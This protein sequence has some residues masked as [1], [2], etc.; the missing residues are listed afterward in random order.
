MDLKAIPQIQDAWVYVSCEVSVSSSRLSWTSWHTSQPSTGYQ[1]ERRS[2][3][4]V[5]QPFL[6]PSRGYLESWLLNRCIRLEGVVTW[7][8]QF[9]VHTV[10]GTTR[11]S[12]QGILF[13]LI[14]TQCI[15]PYSS[16]INIAIFTIGFMSGALMAH[17]QEECL[18][19]L[20]I[21]TMYSTLTTPR[22]DGRPSQYQIHPSLGEGT[23][24]KAREEGEGPDIPTSLA[25]SGLTRTPV[26]TAPG[27]VIG[28][29][30]LIG[31]GLV[32]SLSAW[33]TRSRP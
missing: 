6:V 14:I 24:Q 17:H 18:G 29:W 9:T 1:S 12:Q 19:I 31:P 10:I 5:R 22:I 23:N 11:G 13:V 8:L 33:P 3:G 21:G 7:L 30:A 27:R 26:W 28:I 15:I 32:C 2:V 16:R 4:F 20:R 25:I